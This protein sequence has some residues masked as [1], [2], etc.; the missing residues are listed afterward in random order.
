M[1]VEEFSCQDDDTDEGDRHLSENRTP[2]V[3]LNMSYHSV[4]KYSTKQRSKVR[5]F[6]DQYEML[7]K[8]LAMTSVN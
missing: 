1:E 6:N 5:N 7:S 3:G 2:G 4:N 8:E